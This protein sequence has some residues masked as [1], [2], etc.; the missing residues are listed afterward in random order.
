MGCEQ[1]GPTFR[2]KGAT[3]SNE[4]EIDS[5]GGSPVR[6]PLKAT[7]FFF[8]ARV[9]SLAQAPLTINQAVQQALDRYPAV[10]ASLEQV[11]AAA[12][13]INLA[14]TAY[15][16]RADFLGEVN[17]AT[18]NNV[19]GMVP[20]QGIIPTI[21]GPAL[22]TN[23]LASVWG[24]AVGTLVTWEPFDFGVRRANVDLA[25]SVREQLSAQVNVTKLQVGTAAADA[26]LSILAAQETV[27]AARA[28]VDRAIVLNQSVEALVN[29]QLRPGA[30][31]SR[32]R[33]ELALAQTQLIQAEEAVE[34]ARAALG[35][36]LGLQ[37][38]TITTQPGPL[39]QLPTQQKVQK[40]EIYVQVA[41]FTA[42]NHPLAIAQ[43]RAIQEVRAREKVL[44]RSYFPRFLLEGMTYGRGTGIRPNGQTGSAVGPDTQNWGLGMAISFPV[45]DIASIRSRRQV[46]MFNERTES[47]RYRQILQD[48]TGQSEKARAILAGAERV[49]QNTPIEL[50]AAR[51]SE[52]QANARYRSGL[53]NIVEVA[54]AERILTQ[55]E[56]DDALARLGVWR[57][58]LGVAAA[59]GDVQP[60]LQ[61]IQ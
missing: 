50:D 43:N 54:E 57:A 40:D 20:P 1:R 34:V 14:R 44:D 53:G 35:Q 17:R 22:S 58:L 12:A 21:S 39:L 55:A 23:S 7:A 56:I 24:T 59:N 2:M 47:T 48:L 31:A 18:H 3:F 13:G 37:P 52:Q 42:A 45:F 60:F 33:A 51:V 16:P 5:A 8:L 10:R 6:I 25:A 32:T 30:D 9:C 46:E 49:A 38:Q 29:N 19:F 15:L 61:Q 36:L 26:F 27:T 11:S 41:G 4:R 28:G